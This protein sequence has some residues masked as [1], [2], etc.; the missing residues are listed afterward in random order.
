MNHPPPVPP[1]VEV[2]TVQ[3]AGS[4]WRVTSSDGSFEGVFADART[5]FRCAKAEAEAHPGHVVSFIS[6]R[7]AA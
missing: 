5:A 7:Q 3:P 1:A 6:L 2:M 4:R